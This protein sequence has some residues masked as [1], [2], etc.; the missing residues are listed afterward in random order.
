MNIDYLVERLTSLL[1]E[2]Q[3]TAKFWLRIWQELHTTELGFRWVREHDRIYSEMVRLR[4]PTFILTSWNNHY[5]PALLLDMLTEGVGDTDRLNKA[6][7]L[8]MVLQHTPLYY[9]PMPHDPDFLPTTRVY[10][11]NKEDY[12]LLKRGLVHLSAGSAIFAAKRM[13]GV[14]ED[15]AVEESDD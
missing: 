4:L 8:L 5:M 12:E 14:L 1:S 9:V 3:E 6:N 7:T 15:E 10:K 11:G 2:R 13:C